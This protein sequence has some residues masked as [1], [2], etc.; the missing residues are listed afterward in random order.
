MDLYGDGCNPS[1]TVIVLDF[2]KSLSSEMVQ[3]R[4]FVKLLMSL[5]QATFFLFYGVRDLQL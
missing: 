5:I 3:A 2:C 1:H 4:E